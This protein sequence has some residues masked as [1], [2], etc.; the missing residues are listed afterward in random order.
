MEAGGDVGGRAVGV[1]VRSGGQVRM[2]T[3]GG[4]QEGNEGGQPGQAPEGG[5]PSVGPGRGGKPLTWVDGPMDG[6]SEVLPG[7]LPPSGGSGSTRGSPRCVK[8][9]PRHWGPLHQ[10]LKRVPG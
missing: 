7:W 10:A 8:T 5:V 1:G 4:L 6:R 9:P 2:V 3:L